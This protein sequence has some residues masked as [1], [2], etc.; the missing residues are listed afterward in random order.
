[1]LRFRY[2]EMR[3]FLSFGNVAQ[4]VE[5]ECSPLTIILGMNND[6]TNIEGDEETRNGVGKS[7]VIQALNFALY[8]KSVGNKIKVGNLVNKTNKRHCEV[9][10]AFEKDGVNYKII[11]KR[12]PTDLKFFIGDEDFDEMC[13]EQDDAQGDN[14]DSQHT[15]TEI[16]GMSQELFQQ[17]VTITTSVDSFLGLGGTKQRQIIEE[18]LGITQLSEKADKLKE[19]LKQVKET[20]NRE[21]FRV[22]T[23]E[24]SNTKI[25]SSIR[26]L[27]QQ[28]V[29]W[30][31][32]RQDTFTQNFSA[33]EVLTAVDIEAEKHNQEEKRIAL[34]HNQKAA[35]QDVLIQQTQSRASQWEQQQLQKIVNSES[36]INQLQNINIDA[37]LEA[38]E[39]LNVWNQLNDIRNSNQCEMLRLQ[40]DEAA[41][42][43]RQTAHNN[44]IQRLTLQLEKAYE[45]K[46]PT[47]G[48]A[49]AD[50]EHE[51]IVSDLKS[52]I[53]S[54][55][56]SLQSCTDE[57]QE[58]ATNLQK[59]D[60]FEM[61]VMPV[62]QYSNINDAYKH[63]ANLEA[64]QNEL[65]NLK[66]ET[67]PYHAQLDEMV[68]IETKV[69]PETHYNNIAQVYQHI[70]AI[71]KLT[72]ENEALEAQSNPYD[73]QVD[74]LRND[75]LQKVDYDELNRLRKLQEH[76]EFLVKLLT[77]KNSYVRKRIIDQNLSFLNARLQVYM[78]KSGSMHNVVFMN[79][80]SVDITKMGENYDFDNLS[81]GEK[82][83]VI[84]ALSMAF[85]DMFESLNTSVNTL[86]IDEILD[87]GLDKAGTN[88]CYKMLNDLSNQ[89]DK[90]CFLITHREELQSR[91]ENIMMVVMENGFTTV[92]QNDAESL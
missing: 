3:N 60:S 43:K 18:L 14:R 44:E 79:D 83:R 13:K 17:I 32:K 23:I 87:N 15:I 39:S 67:N 92:E 26:S 64:L 50:E 66:S 58:I 1:M 62:V 69:V 80:L 25:M 47:C 37:E 89:R 28:S 74:T 49:L 27:E 59:I 4:R 24:A 35:D 22:E 8:G 84:I 63:Q 55:D 61:P 33:L 10:L 71:D 7:S 6:A 46:C 48:G 21:Q 12:G 51:H 45:A 73:L 88:S 30:A 56:K 52:R 68:G 31:Q 20:I 41:W 16:V 42:V 9:T 11:R 36:A 76:Q 86:M 82:N 72:S 85:R 29:D 5:L 38:H 2:I 57:L 40:R 53:D 34:E 54:E 90:N 65:S 78:E 19:M 75:S 70:S 91:C 81:R 77:D